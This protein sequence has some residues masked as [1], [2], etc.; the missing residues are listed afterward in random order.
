M[1]GGNS[2][3]LAEQSAKEGINDLRQSGILKVKA[4]VTSLEEL[5]RVTKD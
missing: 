4:G 5:N 2:M 3:E 1:R